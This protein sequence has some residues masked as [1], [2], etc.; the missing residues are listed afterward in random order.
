MDFTSFAVALGLFSTITYGLVDRIKSVFPA[1]TS[2]QLAGASLV[3]GLAVPFPVAYSTFG[4]T[5]DIGG[6]SLDNVNGWGLLVLGLLGSAGATATHRILGTKDG[7]AIANIGA[8][9][10]PQ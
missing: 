6:I 10:D 7:G 1:L 5:V 2:A 8:N 3:I 9:Q 4:H